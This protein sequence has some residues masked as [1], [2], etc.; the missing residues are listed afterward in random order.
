MEW[1]KRKITSVRCNVQINTKTT[2]NIS[3][4]WNATSGA[5]YNLYR[6]DSVDGTYTK[7]CDIE[8]EILAIYFVKTWP[9]IKVL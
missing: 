3:L 2:V 9:K 7:L 8:S 6:S 5:S 1:W 4:L